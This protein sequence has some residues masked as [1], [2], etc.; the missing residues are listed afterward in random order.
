MMSLVLIVKKYQKIIK[1]R[2]L[3]NNP[4]DKY[5]ERVVEE[6]IYFKEQTLNYQRFFNL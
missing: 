5:G 6:F 1:N 3:I 2:D 4:S